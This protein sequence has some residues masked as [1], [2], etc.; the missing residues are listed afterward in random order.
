MME[1]LEKQSLTW[2]ETILSTSAEQSVE[3]DY[4]LPDYEPP[5]FQVLRAVMHPVIQSTRISGSKL[6]L[7]GTAQLSV[8]YINE[9]HGTLSLLEQNENFSKTVD[10]KMPA[11]GAQ[12]LVTAQPGYLNCRAVNRRRIDLRGSINLRIQLLQE[13]SMDC[14]SGGEGLELHRRE[15]ELC[16]RTLFTSREWSLREDLEIGAG[17]E[18]ITQLLHYRAV[19]ILEECRT[20]SGQ[21]V[22]KGTVKLELLAATEAHPEH[23]QRMEFQLPFGQIVDFPGLLESDAVICPLEALQFDVDLQTEENGASSRFSVE[24]L[25]R[26]SAQAAANEMRSLVDDC[27]VL[28][29]AAK[30]QN[31]ICTSRRL[32]QT[33]SQTQIAEG[34]LNLSSVTLHEVFDLLCGDPQFVWQQE[35][36]ALKFSG[37]IP[38]S[39]L[40]LDAENMPQMA[41]QSLSFEWTVSADCGNTSLEWEPKLLLKHADYRLISDQ[42]VEVRLEFLLEGMLFSLTPLP[43]IRDVSVLEEEKTTPRP[44]LVLYYAQSG[45]SLWSIAKHYR[46]PLSAMMEENQLEGETLKEA[47]M[48]LIPQST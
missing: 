36:G 2:M 40:G 12:V 31:E 34:R 47:Q 23:P 45:E 35:N 10:L 27:Y 25:L 39:I 41:E 28:R 42:E 9:E 24:I 14:V 37:S 3:L 11:D 48:L 33:I 22:L 18:A 17:Q 20:L 4:L 7:D 46:A 30:I 6:V 5:V 13:R 38:V 44:A 8:L 32:L 21:L 15:Q 29:H 1:S 26:A 19:P 43:V 16:T